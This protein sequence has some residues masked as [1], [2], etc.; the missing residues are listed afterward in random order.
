VRLR[1]AADNGWL[2][3]LPFLHTVAALP[4][5][6][7]AVVE[8]TEGS[9]GAAQAALLEDPRVESV[10]DDP[11]IHSDV[12]PNDQEF[13]RQW[14]L[15]MA[16]VPYAWELTHGSGSVMLAVLDSGVDLSHPDLAAKLA[17]IGCNVVADRVCPADGHGTPAQDDD[18][19]GSAVAGIA[20]AVTDNKA[21]IAGVAWN[22]SIMPVKVETGQTGHESD[23]IAGLMWAVD[24]GANV[25]NFSFS[26]DCGAAESAALRD[27]LAYAWNHGAL[28][29]ASAGNDGGCPAGVYPAADPHVLAVTATDMNDKPLAIANFGPWVRVAA[30]G[31]HIVTT[32]NGGQYLSGSGT[33][34]AAPQVA[35]LAA[36]LFSIA[37]AT[38]QSVVNWIT[39]TCDVPG[40]WNP[41]YG[42]GRVNAYRAVAL[43]LRGSDPHTSSTVTVQTHLVHGWNNLLYLG[44]TR[45][46]DTALAPLAG[47]LGSAYAWDP[48][49]ASW[50]T[51]LPAQA[52]ASNLLLLRERGAYWVYMLSD[53]DFA[54]TPSGTDPPLQLTLSPGWNNVP[55]PA[56]NLPAGLQGF[57]STPASIFAW[58]ATAAQWRAFFPNAS[59][60]SEFTS[61]RS[62]TAY[63]VPVGSPLVVHYQR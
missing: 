24:H 2:A 27:A 42:C 60:P 23:F 6:H 49:Q 58:D 55:L 33:S 32:G 62:D 47:K 50:Q 17:P 26:E 53:A 20:A 18:G 51:Y 59:S 4:Q 10:A 56:G 37:G 28:P 54:M 15:E 30:P 12:E 44:P 7:A 48:V 52:A 13:T 5:L 41:A 9:N 57:S 63:W 38:N 61:L 21:G 22:A 43:A 1:T 16:Q 14:A 8:V 31:D 36:L 35:G 11:S 34:F 40:G 25:L 45:S 46:V 39:S 19:H 29:V 3:Q